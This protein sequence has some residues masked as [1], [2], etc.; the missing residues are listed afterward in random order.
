[1]TAYQL[2]IGSEQLLAAQS[3]D[4]R[5]KAL[6][7]LCLKHTHNNNYELVCT[8]GQWLAKMT[9]TSCVTP[10]IPEGAKLLFDWKNAPKKPLRELS[11]PYCPGFY[12]FD[13]NGNDTKFEGK[14]GALIGLSLDLV[15]P[16]YSLV[17]PK[18]EPDYTI[19]FSADYLQSIC[20]AFFNLTKD[21]T[22]CYVTLQCRSDGGPTLIANTEQSDTNDLQ[23]I[24]MPVK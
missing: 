23:V 10:A 11:N 13:D 17:I 22:K 8:N 14:A 5:Y 19:T 9:S 18:D 15:Y 24:L 12:T 16:D 20:K 4:A 7:S 2:P 3:S 21:K 6:T 1:M